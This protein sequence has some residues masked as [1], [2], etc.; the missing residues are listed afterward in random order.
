MF[1]KTFDVYI[2]D[3]LFEN[4]LKEDLFNI[5]KSNQGKSLTPGNISLSGIDRELF[6][7]VMQFTTVT[8]GEPSELWFAILFK[9]MA[10]GGVG[11]KGSK[12]KKSNIVYKTK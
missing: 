5:I 8:N 9:G 7:L 3:V 6:N 1:G 10:E 2:I 11:G 12:L 4:R